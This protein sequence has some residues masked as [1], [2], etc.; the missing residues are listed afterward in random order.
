MLVTVVIPTYHPKEYLWKTLESL[1]TQTLPSE[2]FEVIVVLNG[3]VEPY[4]VQIRDYIAAA[5]YRFHIQ[6]LT[7]PTPGVSNAR[8]LAIDAAQGIYLTFLDDDD[9]VSPSFLSDL[10]A[11]ADESTIVEANVQNYN[12]ADRSYADDY[13]TRAYRRCEPLQRI[14]L[15]NG[16]S[17]LSS[18]C[19]KLIPRAVVSEDRYCTSVTHGEDALFMAT[20]SPR[21]SRICLSAP[22]AVYFRRVHGASAQYRRRPL[23]KR[24]S[25]TS[26]LTLHYLVL[27]LQ[28]WRYNFPFILTRI[29]A[30]L[31]RCM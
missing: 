7:T 30:T 31:K 23:A 8:N 4:D 12:E 14:T 16:R 22:E 15:F 9:W 10:L 29:A 28:P 26:R 19:C 20:I 5:H 18:S 24:L 2:D 1:Q 27:L 25:N 17:L 21:I 6:L 13:L 3:D 11:Q